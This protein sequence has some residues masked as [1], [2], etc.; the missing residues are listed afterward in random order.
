MG[1]A[2]RPLMDVNLYRVPQDPYNDRLRP[3]DRP[4]AHGNGNN[5]ECQLP[6][7]EGLFVAPIL[8]KHDAKMRHVVVKMQLSHDGGMVEYHDSIS[9]FVVG[10]TG[11]FK[12]GLATPLEDFIQAWKEH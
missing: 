5:C 6:E 7:Y 12:V 4:C 3:V 1:K 8:F 2:A 9:D 11:R 10:C